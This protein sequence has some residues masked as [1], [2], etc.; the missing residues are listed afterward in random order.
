[1]LS[2][3]L[4]LNLSCYPRPWARR[5]S[6][7]VQKPWIDMLLQKV[8]ISSQFNRQGT[9]RW[10]G[11][12]RLRMQIWCITAAVLHWEIALRLAAS[13]SLKQLGNVRGLGHCAAAEATWQHNRPWPLCSS[14]Q[15]GSPDRSLSS[16]GLQKTPPTWQRYLYVSWLHRIRGK[17]NQAE[18]IY[19]QENQLNQY[20]KSR[21]LIK[22]CA[23]FL[24]A[25]F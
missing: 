22:T 11:Q 14:R 15:K 24:Q 3:Q 10:F 7:V 21:E 20:D 9:F 19:T 1:M 2:Q 6:Y 12:S 17:L 5:G 25:R 4:Y 8:C 13:R 16:L 18:G 23:P